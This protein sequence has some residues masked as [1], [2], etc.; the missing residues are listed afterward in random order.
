[1]YE[2]THACS[3]TA[4]KSFLTSSCAAADHAAPGLWLGHVCR[5]LGCHS[6]VQGRSRCRAHGPSCPPG[7][8]K[9]MQGITRGLQPGILVDRAVQSM[10]SGAPMR[11]TAAVGC[12][13]ITVRHVLWACIACTCCVCLVL[14]MTC[15]NNGKERVA[16]PAL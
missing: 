14:H 6:S 16:A 10:A 2:G 1:M 8:Y 4:V 15:S 9:G 13:S 3:H 5:H 12:F 11:R 7:Q